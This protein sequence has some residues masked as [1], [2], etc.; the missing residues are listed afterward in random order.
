MGTGLKEKK[1]GDMTVGELQDLIRK[2]IHEML[3]PDYGLELRPE[4]EED[5]RE[6]M[7]QK[8]RGEGI[9]LEEARKRLGLE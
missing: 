6:S 9:P 4:I 8:E 5:L 7:K 2:T 3:D 1:V